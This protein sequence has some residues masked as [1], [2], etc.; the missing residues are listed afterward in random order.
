MGMLAKYI[1]NI[2]V[3]L[4]RLANTLLFGDPEMT[5]SGRMGIAIKEGSCYLCRPICWVLGK[6][7][8]NH[9]QKEGENEKH[10]GDDELW[11]W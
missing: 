11:K 8:K 10:E 6:L 4:D 3:A 5:L 1:F 7:D 2:L 9:C